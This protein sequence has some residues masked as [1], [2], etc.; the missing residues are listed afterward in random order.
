[1]Q[2]TVVS[3]FEGGR[4]MQA[5][6][7]PYTNV[8]KP[9]LE[10]WGGNWVAGLFDSSW[11]HDGEQVLKRVPC[12][13]VLDGVTLRGVLPGSVV[14]IDGSRYDSPMGGDI[15]LSFQYPGNYVVWVTLWPY[16]DGSY[17]VENPPPT[18]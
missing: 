3:L 9:T 13:A 8:I 6:V 5:V 12:P 14:W 2:P 4:F 18:Q 15:E 16:L 1:M 11:W 17:T 7:G 10:G